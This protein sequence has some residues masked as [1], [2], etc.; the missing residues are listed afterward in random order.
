MRNW[1]LNKKI[2]TIGLI[3]GITVAGISATGFFGLSKL[4]KTL[5][6]TTILYDIESS[7]SALS[8]GH[9]KVRALEANAILEPTV[10]QTSLFPKRMT[11]VYRDWE[12][13]LTALNAKV[14]D[15]SQ[16]ARINELKSTLSKRRELSDKIL[17][18]ALE[19]ENEHA[20]E[21]HNTEEGPAKQLDNRIQMLTEEIIKTER[22][23]ASVMRREVSLVGKTWMY[24]MG[25][26]SA[27]GLGFGL[28]LS[29]AI[30]AG[31]NRSLS[32]T[33][34]NLSESS[35]QF[36]TRSQQISESSTNVA[37]ATTAEA[38]SIGETASTI[39]DIATLSEIGSAN[40]K[41]AAEAAI[42]AVVHAGRSRDYLEN[43]VAAIDDI[44]QYEKNVMSQI[45]ERHKQLAEIVN[46]IAEIK[47]KTKFINDV[48]YQTKL[49]SFNASVEAARAGELGKGFAVVAEELGNLSTLSTTTAK[50]ISALLEESIR[51]ADDLVRE[52]Q[53][54]FESLGEIKRN[55]IDN[56][57]AAAAQC[58]P[59]LSE[60]CEKTKQIETMTNE[61]ATNCEMQ[62]SGL[63]EI[64]KAMVLLEQ[65]MLQ[66]AT[67]ASDCAAATQDLTTQAE[68]V[69]TSTRNLVNSIKGQNAQTMRTRMSAQEAV[70]EVQSVESDTA[71]NEVKTRLRAIPPKHESRSTRNRHQRRHS[72]ENRMRKAAGAEDIHFDD[73]PKPHDA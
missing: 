61:M 70:P 32:R 49:L 42:E 46:V 12:T 15:N 30:V 8:E 14:S 41:K 44:N 54:K 28:L 66:N 23:A 68:G 1:S 58:L 11:D 73:D 9:D 3:F 51:K 6:T 18:A 31:L 34:E 20:F 26:V 13:G 47:G 43:I 62:A 36:L 19:G 16:K 17:K 10:E 29:Q 63:T 48:A 35:N 24:W 72:S 65:V 56:G 27:L 39:K 4:E 45:G 67:N 25:V 52:T 5:D 40:S 59:L 38:K 22:A 71:R 37:A 33:A 2:L 60:L 57:S 53:L 50:D 55:K 69:K 7:F 64:N 21:L